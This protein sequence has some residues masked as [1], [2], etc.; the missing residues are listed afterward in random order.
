[1]F[2]RHGIFNPQ[3]GY[4]HQ[5]VLRR[6]I[7]WLEFMTRAAGSHEL[8]RPVGEAR[9]AHRQQAIARWYEGISA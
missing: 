4:R 5:R 1:M 7:F 2:S 6:H 8:W 3:I 9:D